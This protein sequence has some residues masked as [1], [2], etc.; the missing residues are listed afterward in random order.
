[1]SSPCRHST[2]KLQVL[3]EALPLV[4]QDQNLNGSNGQHNG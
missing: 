3:W 2:A 4:R 1:M